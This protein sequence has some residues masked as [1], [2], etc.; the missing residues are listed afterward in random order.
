MRGL[1]S[2]KKWA[3]A[4][5][6]AVTAGV[7]LAG[8]VGPAPSEDDDNDLGNDSSSQLVDD[9]KSEGTVTMYNAFAPGQSDA[10][11]R[12]F[13]EKYGITVDVLPVHTTGSLITRFS[14]ETTAGAASA[15]LLIVGENGVFESNPT[16]FAEL[17]AEDIPGLEAVPEQYQSERNVA[18]EIVAL[19][20]IISNETPANEMPK[21]WADL[22]DSTWADNMV[23]TDPRGVPAYLGWADALDERY[24]SD[25][26]SDLADQNP[27]FT[28][29]GATGAQQVAAGEK[30]I[31][32]PTSFSQLNGLESVAHGAFLSDPYLGY[33]I[34]G[35]VAEKASSPAAARLLLSY[36]ISEEGQTIIN[37]DA[38][39]AIS[40]LPNIPGSITA[41]LDLLV[42]NPAKAD[43]RRSSLLDALGLD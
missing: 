20:A 32:T 28:S 25:F 10:I 18:V 30:G 16:W 26:L 43:K 12:G 34:F 35:G 6:G 7:V 33:A 42:V 2:K 39:K 11:A 3:L 22:L 8:C 29:S 9:A 5:M 41:P 1:A 15:D 40:V 21:T 14:E 4:L 23:L 37:G 13:E 36:V 17:S 31:S 19:I 24:G 27:T 38:G